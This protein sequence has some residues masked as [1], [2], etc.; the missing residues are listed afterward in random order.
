MVIV[1]KITVIMLSNREA[2]I[3]EIKR[4]LDPDVRETGVPLLVDGLGLDETASGL[5]PLSPPTV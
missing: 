5:F 4:A 2:E 1:V 3:I